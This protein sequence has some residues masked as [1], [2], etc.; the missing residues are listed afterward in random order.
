MNQYCQIENVFRQRRKEFGGSLE[1]LRAAEGGKSGM[2][3]EQIYKSFC[4]FCGE[5]IGFA[6]QPAAVGTRLGCARVW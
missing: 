6:D 5:Q 1:S 4:A 2:T 3:V